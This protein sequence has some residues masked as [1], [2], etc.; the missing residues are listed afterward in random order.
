MKEI[1]VAVFSALLTLFATFLVN[2]RKVKSEADLNEVRA[3]KEI[4]DIYREGMDSLKA[5]LQE[6]RDEL[7]KLRTEVKAL[8]EHNH[9]LE[10]EVKLLRRETKNIGK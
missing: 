4:V 2:R 9:K 10:C 5:E 1:L 7:S 6:A 8:S 3:V